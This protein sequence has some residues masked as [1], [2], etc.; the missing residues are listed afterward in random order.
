M[1]TQCRRLARTGSVG[2][3][4]AVNFGTVG[5]KESLPQEVKYLK[6]LETFQVYGNENTMLLNIELGS[7]ICE[8]KYLKNLQIG[9]YGLVALPK[10][11]SR[12][13]SSLEVLDLSANNFT[14]V[15]EV[16][17]KNDFKKLKSLKIQRLTVRWN[18][19]Q[20]ERFAI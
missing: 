4:R 9:G 18:S 16:L 14:R 11:F 6:Y 20:S 2:R 3:V 19:K 8:L 5:T 7:D 15:P 1:G 13:G 12:L 17:N 10:D